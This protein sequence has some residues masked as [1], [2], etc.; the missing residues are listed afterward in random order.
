MTA[1]HPANTPN[2]KR[3]KVC[4]IEP[5]ADFNGFHIMRMP[6]MGHLYLGTILKQHGYDVR[7]Y[8]ECIK[9]VWHP[10][11]GIIESHILDCDVVALSL[12]TPTANRGYAIADA[13]RKANPKARIIIGGSHASALPEEAIEHA[14]MVVV[15]E[16]EK[17]ILEAVESDEAGII[18]GE[19]MQNLDELPM[20][21][22]RLLHGFRPKWLSVTPI[23]T[24]RGCP[25]DC[26]FCSVTKMFGRK[27]RFRSVESVLDEMARRVEAGYRNFFFYD[28]N[29][30]ADKERTKKLLEGILRRGLKLWWSCQSRVDIAHDDELLDLARRS[31][32]A[33]VCLGV[34]SV[35]PNTL[36]DYNKRQSVSE[37]V[38]CIVKLKA[39]KMRALC[40][41]VLGSDSDS[42]LTIR[43]TVRF[44][45]RWQPRY[46][47]FSILVPLPGTKF[48]QQMEAEGRIW[49]NNWSY[50]DGTH[51]VT[52]PKNFSP[53]Q[54]LDHTRWTFKQFYAMPWVGGYAVSRFLIKR[55]ERINRKYLLHL[56]T[57]KVPEQMARGMARTDDERKMSG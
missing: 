18:K 5:K 30:S 17:R 51:V 33:L 29:F 42:P 28:D 22:L 54:L 41:F 6:L 46:A 14:D 31:G 2:M 9:P 35:N 47:Q 45:K 36:K 21:D 48:R 38:N 50:Y 27:C 49:S 24:S 55:W 57:V 7:N 53:M 39:H 3:Q 40:M 8:S 26:S 34:E 20:M 19:Q 12:M 11:R 10:R 1:A 43:E 37:I 13:V 32:G 16:G 52:Y 23:A 25:F 44:L 4:F 56:P 15:G